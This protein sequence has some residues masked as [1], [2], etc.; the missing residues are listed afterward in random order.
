MKS[1]LGWKTLW[2]MRANY[3]LLVPPRSTVPL[4]LS[5]CSKSLETSSQSNE[6]R[7]WQRPGFFFI[8]MKEINRN[9]LYSR[10]KSNSHF[11]N[12]E[13]GPSRDLRDFMLGGTRIIQRPHPLKKKDPGYAQDLV[14]EGL[15]VLHEVNK[16]RAQ[17]VSLFLG[18]Q[19]RPRL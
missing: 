6:F 10:V 8:G 9:L 16:N 19:F 11:F 15:N 17:F 2:A 1:I 12:R 18:P 3:T 4:F 14:G 5:I 7:T 13:N